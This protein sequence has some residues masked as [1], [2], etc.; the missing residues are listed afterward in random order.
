MLFSVYCHILIERIQYI[1]KVC[2]TAYV[3]HKGIKANHPL[4]IIQICLVQHSGIDKQTDR[5]Q[6]N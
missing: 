5:E 4:W 2:F 3:K 1:G 6:M